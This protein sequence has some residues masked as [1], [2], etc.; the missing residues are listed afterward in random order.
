MKT[1]Q[2]NCSSSDQ[3][4]I[5]MPREF[6]NEFPEHL[7]QC[8]WLCPISLQRTRQIKLTKIKKAIFF[9]PL[10][11]L[12]TFLL[13][14]HFHVITRLA[15]ADLVLG[16]NRTEIGLRWT[17]TVHGGRIQF[18]TETRYAGINATVVS[19]IGKERRTNSIS[20][21]SNFANSNLC[22]RF[23]PAENFWEF[24]WTKFVRLERT[25]SNEFHLKTSWLL[26]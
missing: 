12:V 20:L 9:S 4:G 21:F 19:C 2:E 15:E 18:A 8:L 17:Q 25:S 10:N 13:C 22:W 6:R 23:S 14:E 5:R 11:W 26:E 7:C 16:S 3:V 24:L 1:F